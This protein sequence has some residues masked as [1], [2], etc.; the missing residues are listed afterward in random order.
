M[1]STHF[2][3]NISA[4]Q[5]QIFRWQGKKCCECRSFDQPAKQDQTLLAWLQSYPH[6]VVTLLTDLAEEHY[7][8]EV[9][10]HVRGQARKALLL[11]KLATWPPAAGFH[12]VTWLDSLQGLR[13]EDRY[14]YTGVSMDMWQGALQLLQQHSI[15][16][17]GIYLQTTCLSGW[18]ASLLPS[19]TQVLCL[20][21]AIQ[22]CRLS[23]V[24]QGKLFFSR[25][26][27]LPE[28]M[29]EA[30]LMNEINQTR[31]Y[32]QHQRWLS[33]GEQLE[34]L[35]IT[36][37]PVLEGILSAAIVPA[38]TKQHLVTPFSL[39]QRLGLPMPDVA[40]S[41][42]AWTAMHGMMH[43][44]AANHA[45]SELLFS[46]CLQRVRGRLY[47]ATISIA[48][49]GMLGMLNMWQQQRLL[50]Q[51]VTY[52]QPLNISVTDSPVGAFNDKDLP[53]MQALVDA[54]QTLVVAQRTPQHLMQALQQA[55]TN[56][57]AWQLH[58]VQ[59]QYGP[60][61][62]GQPVASTGWQEQA[63]LDFVKRE[64]ISTEDAQQEWEMLL[65]TLGAQPTFM[66]M[67]SGLVKP[68][69]PEVSAEGDTRLPRKTVSVRR[70]LHVLL[71]SS[72]AV[73]ISVK[74]LP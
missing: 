50:Q 38:D 34:L 66:Q 52:Q 26:L 54:A 8:I 57:Q 12:A 68:D 14:L 4:H 35:C 51:S 43:S 2:L 1:A 20:H 3:I 70:R 67:T 17:S 44:Q 6:S 37:D 31:M 62:K 28:H 69:M 58:K 21:G 65:A 15:A 60:Q 18:V 9:L 33:E 32:V 45:T 39:F 42:M 41:A 22:Q 19:A 40:I 64:G 30:V 61:E 49:I 29:N 63:W 47:W 59:W 25:Q 72:E 24:Y 13:R 46:A 55:C 56:M 53:G 10:P 74:R 7:H 36:E 16:V 48:I 5:W 11:R 71:A 73:E 27:R 23:Y